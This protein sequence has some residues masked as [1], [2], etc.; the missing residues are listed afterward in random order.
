M[1]RKS[2]TESPPTAAVVS[3]NTR[4]GIEIFCRRRSAMNTRLWNRRDRT[5]RGVVLMVVMGL[6][7]MF[8]LIAITFVLSATAHRDAAKAAANLEQ[9]GDPPDAM[10]NGALYQVIRGSRNPR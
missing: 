4:C 8:M 2:A 7:A 6:L 5:R 3:M 10:L 9:Y 1:N